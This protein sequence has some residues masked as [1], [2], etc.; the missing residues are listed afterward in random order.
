MYTY[1]VLPR[2]LPD[3]LRPQLLPSEQ[4]D[5]QI[6]KKLK[7]F[8]T[9]EAILQFIQHCLTEEG[10]VENHTKLT[11][12]LLGRV[13]KL[14]KNGQFTPAQKSFM[15]YLL[16]DHR[17]QLP[18]DFKFIHKETTFETNRSL[19]GILNPDFQEKDSLDI[20]DMSVEAFRVITGY[21]KGDDYPESIE[22]DVLVELLR[23]IDEWKLR[24]QL[25]ED[26]IERC[27]FSIQGMVRVYQAAAHHEGIKQK[28]LKILSEHIDIKDLEIFFQLTEQHGLAELKKIALR[29][30]LQEIA[31]QLESI[32]KD[33]TIENER[34]TVAGI[35]S[36]FPFFSSYDAFDENDLADLSPFELVVLFYVFPEK[37]QALNLSIYTDLEIDFLAQRFPLYIKSLNLSN[38][39]LT[40]ATIDA[41]SHCRFLERLILTNVMSWNKQDSLDTGEVWSDLVGIK[42]LKYLDV[43][44]CFAAEPYLEALIMQSPDLEVLIAGRL[45]EE[46]LANRCAEHI[47]Q[48]PLKTL[49]F[50]GSYL[51]R[52]GI[53]LLA[54]SESLKNNLTNLFIGENPELNQED[55]MR[56]IQAFPNLKTL[57]FEILRC[58]DSKF[59][60]E[61]A[62]LKFLEDIKFT[63]NSSIQEEDII[64]LVSHCPIL[65]SLE[66]FASLSNI[67][68]T[69][70][71]CEA[72]ATYCPNLERLVSNCVDVTPAGLQ[73]LLTNEKMN[74]QE[75]NILPKDL[76]KSIFDEAAIYKMILRW[77]NLKK[78][79]MRLDKKIPLNCLKEFFY[80]LK[81]L[82]T[83][84]FSIYERPEAIL[85]I[86]GQHCEKLTSL[87]ILPEALYNTDLMKLKNLK[88]LKMLG[89]F[90]IPTEEN[91][92]LIKSFFPN[93]RKLWIKTDL[94]DLQWLDSMPKLR[95]LKIEYAP[96]SLNR[97][98]AEFREF[99]KELMESA[100]NIR[101]FA[102]I[103]R[104][105]P[106]YLAQLEFSFLINEEETMR[107]VK[108]KLIDKIIEIT[109]FSK[110]HN[111]IKEIEKM[112]DRFLENASKFPKHV[113]FCDSLIDVFKKMP[114]LVTIKIENLREPTQEQLTDLL[115]NNPRLRRCTFIN[116]EGKLQRWSRE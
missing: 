53:E 93:L 70:R 76:K 100:L 43:T 11:Q 44:N 114:R 33:T 25:I 49:D 111:L 58:L 28:V 97:I 104:T 83:L 110:D 90:V 20:S 91:F 113:F 48:H 65:R 22:A 52:K 88:N 103:D 2:S 92:T 9:P 89:A 82:R 39:A 115:K 64:F 66:V 57:H 60:R 10:Y 56:I 109:G 74:L 68:I 1:T 8:L 55:L 21:L 69:D 32:A 85:S 71:T 75:L 59:V 7:N 38:A 3:S 16:W 35:V 112:I 34:A 96:T 81:H 41:V 27:P 102:T 5:D 87:T 63:M 67:G 73:A 80:Q 101:N 84:I 50:S 24:S 4:S 29:K 94:R 99:S 19:L 78:V 45:G 37:V 105:L 72:L 6:A 30:A 40:E 54:S 47:R 95:K 31:K 106:D 15:I 51:D 14:T 79:C 108:E 17:E 46:E 42:H 107:T 12:K 13:F 77:P 86:I 62:N 116:P 26:L 18:K 98:C 23:K 36:I 61:L